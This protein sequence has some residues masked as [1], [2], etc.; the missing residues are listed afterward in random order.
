MLR[1]SCLASCDSSGE[2]CLSHARELGWFHPDDNSGGKSSGCRGIK[3]KGRRPRGLAVLWSLHRN[4]PTWHLIYYVIVY[5]C[6]LL[7]PT[8]YWGLAAAASACAKHFWALSLF[9]EKSLEAGVFFFLSRSCRY[10]WVQGSCR[11]LRWNSEPCEFVPKAPAL[12]TFQAYL[13]GGR[14]LHALPCPTP[15]HLS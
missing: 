2:E 15:S 13:P 12:T 11:W 6:I 7:I 9:S 10:K 3:V 14:T 4:T 1:S 8:V 5:N